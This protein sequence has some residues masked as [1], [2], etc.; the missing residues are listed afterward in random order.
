VCR[1][2]LDI[3]ENVEKKKGVS[4]MKFFLLLDF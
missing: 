4:D 3:R 1:W 2:V